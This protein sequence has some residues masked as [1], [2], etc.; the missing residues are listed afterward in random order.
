MAGEVETEVKVSVPASIAKLVERIAEASR[1]GLWG[2]LAFTLKAGKPW[3]LLRK[4][5]TEQL[6]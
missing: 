1:K 5:T 6:E 2:D 3:G 4:S